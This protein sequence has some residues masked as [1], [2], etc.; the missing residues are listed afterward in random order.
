MKRPIALLLLA[1]LGLTGVAQAVESVTVGTVNNSD[2]VRM[3]RLSQVFEKQ[4]PD[5]K[6]NWVVLE[7]NVLRQRLT[8]DITTG[9]GQFDVLTIGTYETP[10][11]GAKNWLEPLDNLPASYDVEDI[12]PAVRQGLSVNNR[13]YALPFYG[14]STVTYYRKDLFKAAGLQMPDKPTWT[15]LAAFASQL[16]QPDKEQYGLCLRGKAGW[17]ENVALLSLMGTPSARAGSTNNGSPN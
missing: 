11:W 2:M 14:E 13:L 1:G 6:L 4:H 9:G 8:T 15:Q 7:E 17:G 10:L 16:N 12:F 5:I 3:Q